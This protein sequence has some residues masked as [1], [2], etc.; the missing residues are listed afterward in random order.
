[1][2]VPEEKKEREPTESTG[3]LLAKDPPK[4]MSVIK[5]SPRTQKC[6]S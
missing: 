2:D 3:G 1:M 4:V 6:K 5:I